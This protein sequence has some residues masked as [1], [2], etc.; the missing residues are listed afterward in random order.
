[1]K[2]SARGRALDALPLLLKQLIKL[3]FM[4]IKRFKSSTMSPGFAL[5]L[6]CIATSGCG[7]KDVSDAGTPPA[8][9]TAA[10]GVNP[11]A[12]LPPDPVDMSRFTKAFAAAEPGL[13]LYAEE[14]VAV[15]R[16]RAFADGAEQLQKLSRNPKL[17][18]EQ[19]AAIQDLAGR[20][21]GAR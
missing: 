7:K 6:A 8:S 3:H 17:N 12:A 9:G 16:A 10:A 5:L 11:A 4:T 18:A 1:L 15:I 21:A 2:Q 14:T 20:L 19:R 13:K